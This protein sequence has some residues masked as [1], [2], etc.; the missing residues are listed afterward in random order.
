MT[1]AHPREMKQVIQLIDGGLNSPPNLIEIPPELWRKLG[2]PI[3][4][5]GSQSEFLPTQRA[6]HSMGLKRNLCPQLS[7]V[8]PLHPSSPKSPL[9]HQESEN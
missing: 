7:G 3:L 5:L 8:N 6:S 1:R 9:A 4:T 2:F